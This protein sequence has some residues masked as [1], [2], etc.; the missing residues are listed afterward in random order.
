M[1]HG[2]GS[3]G[4][5]T[6]FMAPLCKWKKAFVATEKA[7][8]MLARPNSVPLAM[9]DRGTCIDRRADAQKASQRSKHQ[10]FVFI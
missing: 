5:P 4:P 1:D 2:V 7:V 3:L 10:G 8:G 9:T 6:V